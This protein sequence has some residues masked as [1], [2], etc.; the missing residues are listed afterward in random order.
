MQPNTANDVPDL[1]VD[2]TF[3][4]EHDL[5]EQFDAY[6]EKYTYILI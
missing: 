2:F 4:L 6:L 5:G 1:S 3:N